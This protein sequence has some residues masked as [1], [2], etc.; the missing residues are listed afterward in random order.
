MSQ[1]PGLLE[2]LFPKE[3]FG[4]IMGEKGC[5]IKSLRARF[6]VRITSEKGQARFGYR[7]FRIEGKWQN[8]WT[9][10]REMSRLVD[11]ADDPEN[12]HLVKKDLSLESSEM[13]I[14]PTPSDTTKFII[15]GCPASTITTVLESS[16]CQESL[17]QS[18]L[19]TTKDSSVTDRDTSESPSVSAKSSP[20]DMEIIQTRTQRKRIFDETS[21]PERR[22][23]V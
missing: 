10:F 6:D 11:G 17:L 16:A 13:T 20:S 12:L 4:V 8:T 14:D 19:C 7:C 15:T 5:K 22:F 23:T 3:C 1:Q 21:N 2:V 9:A 18:R